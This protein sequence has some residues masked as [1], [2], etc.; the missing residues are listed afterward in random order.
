MITI[1]CSCNSQKP[2]RWFTQR[3]EE[4]DF[5]PESAQS[6]GQLAPVSGGF[7][8]TAHTWA[9]ASFSRIRKSTTGYT[10]ILCVGSFTSHI[11]GTTGFSVSS[12]RHRRIWGERNRLS[13]E[14][15]V[16]GIGPPFPRLTVRRSTAR[17]PLP[18]PLNRWEGKARD[19]RYVTR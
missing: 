10:F 7:P 18:R 9:N 14:T 11:E 13:F 2:S 3:R 1:T 4:S 6:T 16:G 5:R 19:A 12:E 8:Q 15:A 17:S